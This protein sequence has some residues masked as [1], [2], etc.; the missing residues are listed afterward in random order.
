MVAVKGQTK[1]KKSKSPK[2]RTSTPNSRKKRKTNVLKLLVTPLVRF[3]TS[4]PEE[5]RN[6]KMFLGFPV[7][8]LLGFG[9]YKL[10]ITPMSLGEDSRKLA[11]AM[12]VFAMASGFA[13]SAGFRCMC[14][15]LV[16]TFMGKAGRSYIGTFAIVYLISGPIENMV[17]NAQDITRSLTCAA[18]LSANQTAAKWKFRL[19]PVGNVLKDMQTEGFMLKKMGKRVNRA[20]KPIRSEIQGEAGVAENEERT[21]W[22]DWNQGIDRGRA[23]RVEE[24]T[25]ADPND[26]E[27][28]RIEK[29]YKKKINFQCEDVYNLAK[30]KCK[31]TMKNFKNRCKS[32]LSVLLGWLCG[33][34]HP[35]LCNILGVIGKALGGECNTDDI[36]KPSFGRMYASSEKSIDSMDKGFEVEIKYKI[37]ESKEA[38]DYSSAEHMRSNALHEFKN[39][40]QWLE[41]IFTLIK[42][43][44]AFTF[45]L[46]LFRAYKYYQKYVTDMRFDNNYI[47]SYFKKIDARRKLKGKR[48]LLPLKKLEAGSCINT[49]SLKLMASEK[50]KLV[51]GSVLILVRAALAGMIFFV[52]HILFTAMDIIRRH[53]RVDFRQSGINHVEVKV[54]GTGFM[55]QLVRLFMKGLN[56]K[57]SMDDV[58]SNLLCL[59]SPKPVERRYYGIVFGIYAALW[60]LILLDAYALRLRRLV[61]AFFFRKREKQRILYLYN[62]LQKK[63]RAFL[64]DMRRKIKTKARKLK[65]K[66]R[67]GLLE[68]LSKRC[69]CL[70]RC[71]KICASSKPACLVCGERLKR[72]A[73]VRCGSSVCTFEYCKECWRDL[74]KRCYACLPLKEFS[75]T[76]TGSDISSEDDM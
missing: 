49:I 16:P 72:S 76:D 62:T 64:H 45:L 51:K 39:G 61:S 71:F 3:F 32:A 60:L 25:A 42:R 37:V 55:S 38:I 50:G 35:G 20:F 63:R 68:A 17:D 65:L 22:E 59:P 23:A 10:V 21:V 29:K 7:G 33:I 57:A 46:V 36:V 44:L 66:K 12:T 48:V 54:G 31:N 5:Y 56:T 26:D 43:A 9:L 19:K 73:V 24:Q 13:L 74:K 28:R 2:G 75:S 11:G 70:R 30:K 34:F 27:G 14:C 1:R 47:T 67:S 58:S 4:E 8:A 41:F 18:E 40:R 53:S 52:A 15:L 6:W 69:P